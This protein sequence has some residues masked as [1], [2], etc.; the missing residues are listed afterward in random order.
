MMPWSAPLTPQMQV[1]AARYGA[2]V[3]VLC[4]ARLRM[5]APRLSDFD[6]Y[7]KIA[8]TERGKYLGGPMTE[9]EAWDDFARMTATWILRGHGVWTAENDDAEVVGFVLIGFE[10]GDLEPELG[11]LFLPESEGKGLASEAA[12]AVRDHAFDALG[13]T[14]LVSYIDPANTRAKALSLRMGA[15]AEG[16]VDGSD[17]WRHVRRIV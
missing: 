17:V 10:P 2:V 6:A 11:F 12:T 15:V 14:T 4:T 7:R 3:P 16:Q 13:L 8:C 5:R 9:T 1:A